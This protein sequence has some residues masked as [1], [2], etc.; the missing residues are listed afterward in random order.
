M[1]IVAFNW[2]PTRR[3]LRGF[4]LLWLPLTLG[5]V[6]A[7]L[8]VKAI[9][10]MP[11]LLAMGAGALLAV[12]G[13]L[14]APRLLRPVFVGLALVTYPIGFV[15]SHVVVAILFFVFLTSLAV[16][17]RLWGRDKL[18]LRF[19]RDARSY[20]VPRRGRAAVERYF[21]QY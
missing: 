17:M 8:A 12:L 1:A 7:V 15:V 6:G 13:G 11:L 19:D 21:W 3:Q 5:G 16:P 20:W 18:G 9:V 2:N 4:G 10:T 14:V